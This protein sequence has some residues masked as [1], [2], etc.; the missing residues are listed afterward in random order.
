MRVSGQ[1]EQVI[2]QL[3]SYWQVDG[4]RLQKHG[5]DGELVKSF[6]RSCENGWA[7]PQPNP[8]TLDK[9]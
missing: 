7:Q 8:K 1:N 9:L 3:R 4:S 5:S 2:R 6:V